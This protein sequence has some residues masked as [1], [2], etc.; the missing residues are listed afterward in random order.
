[1]SPVVL[2]ESN[3]TTQH[4]GRDLELLLDPDETWTIEDLVKSDSKAEWSPSTKET[5]SFGYRKGAVWARVAI[6]DQRSNPRALVVELPYAPLDTIDFYQVATSGGIKHFQA[7]DHV[8]RRDWALETRLPTAPLILGPPEHS[9]WLYVRIKSSSSLI[10]DL[11]LSDE[12]FAFSEAKRD[13][14]LQAF[15]FGAI[16]ILSLYNLLIYFATRLRFYAAYV[17]YLLGYAAVQGSLSGLIHAS[18]GIDLPSLNDYLITVGISISGI[19][20]CIFVLG[21]F[22]IKQNPRR[23]K[24]WKLLNGLTIALYAAILVSSLFTPY[25]YNLKFTFTCVF[26]IA[27]D[28][29]LTIYWGFLERERMARWFAIAFSGFVVGSLLMVMRNLGWM[30]PN[31]L[32]NYAL[33][34]GSALEFTLLSFAMADRIKILQDKIQAEQ[35]NALKAEQAAREADHRALQ[36]S[37]VALAEQKRLAALKDQFLANTSHELR[38]PLNGMIGMSEHVLNHAKLS[39]EDSRNVQ[40]ILGASRRLS[41][42]VNEILDF[43][44]TQQGSMQV[45]AESLSLAALVKASLEHQ[46]LQFAQSKL[47][48]ENFLGDEPWGIQSDRARTLQVLDAILSN[49]YKFSVQGAITL[50]ARELDPMI[51]L[52][53]SDTGQGIEADRLKNLAEGFEQGDGSA[54]R[55]QGG[56][57]LGLALAYRLMQALGGNL[58]V[59]S[60]PGVGTTVV[61]RFPKSEHVPA[62]QEAIPETAKILP[63]SN[64]T[65]VSQESILTQQ[66]PKPLSVSRVS[67]TLAISVSPQGIGTPTRP[68][69]RGQDAKIL[70]VDDDDLNR[71]VIR[72]HLRDTS[73]DIYEANSGASALEAMAQHAP[74]DAVLLDVMMPG[75]TGYEVCRTL[76]QSFPAQELPVLMLTAKQ[77]IHD[78]IEGFSAGANDYVH[79]P[80]D[81]GELLVRLDTHLQLARSAR[82]MRRFVPQDFIRLLGYERLSEV[83]LGDSVVQNMS[84]V[85][86]DIK[87][88]TSALERMQTNEVFEW[89]NRCYRILGP[90]IRKSGGFVDKYIGDAVMALFPRSPDDA[91][92]AAVAMHRGLKEVS[93]FH[94]GTGIHFGQTMLG[95]LGEPERFEATVLSDAVNIASR[96]EGA[97]KILGCNI[98]VTGEVRH[99]MQ[100]P[101]AYHWRRL[102]LY[103][104]KG[105][106]SAIE[107]FEI[108]DVALD[109]PLKKSHAEEF[110]TGVARFEAGDFPAAMMHFQ[111]VLD[112]NPKDKAADF[113]MQRA[114]Y[115]LQDKSSFDGTIHLKEKT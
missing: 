7:G 51:E 106:T 67:G 46:K 36:A 64:A 43:S 84:I 54:G 115:L 40:E 4:L 14:S 81:K 8:P 65:S 44:S 37:E 71:K 92:A 26:F 56:T 34:I 98:V 103:R 39:A 113:L 52:A 58:E 108:L 110:E 11:R 63:F 28:A 2:T 49:A 24:L 99:H 12:R 48:I 55:K 68:E 29:W 101:E 61:L 45:N 53:I 27:I 109:A 10:M 102:G 35:E 78:L 77:Q 5:P 41:K 17:S 32:T 69:K 95:T 112:E 9:L 80:F 3:F 21:V 86:A 23:H 111:T 25:E 16:L 105:R 75:M 91:V 89:L 18:F 6:Q 59:H 87:D 74:F 97:S 30:A 50:R 20:F 114:K 57:G 1:M 82:S 76:R 73:Y 19:G 66:A 90:E 42:I 38:T 13:D 15:Y 94:L 60:S 33:Q 104:L 79:K 62:E 31:A 96:V 22:E 100:D 93:D 72:S 85:F 83:E 47:E 107:L 88:F 70:V